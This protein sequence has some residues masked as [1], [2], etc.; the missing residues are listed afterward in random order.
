MA[1]TTYPARSSHIIF[2]TENDFQTIKKKIRENAIVKSMPLNR[3]GM[4]IYRVLGLKAKNFKFFL[5]FYLTY[6]DV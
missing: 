6:T 3:P 4:D 1:L 5:A 2:K